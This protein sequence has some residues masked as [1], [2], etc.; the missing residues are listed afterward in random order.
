MAHFLK[1]IRI[2][3]VELWKD[4]LLLKLK[5]KSGHRCPVIEHL[6]CVNSK[7]KAKTWNGQ[8]KCIFLESSM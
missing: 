2:D 7:E 6:F 5:F 3:M 1:K 4:Q 8:L